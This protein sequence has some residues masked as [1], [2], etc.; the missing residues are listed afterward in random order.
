MDCIFVVLAL[1]LAG[2][3]QP[4]PDGPIGEVAGPGQAVA[5]PASQCPRTVACQY[6]E[7]NFLPSGYRV[8][9]LLVC[10]ANCTTQYWV[11]SSVD[12]RQL[13]EIDPVR[14]GGVLAVASAATDDGHASVRS[15]LPNYAPGDAGCCPSAFADV[16]YT[17][18]PSANS[19]LSGEP[20]LTPASD[21]PGWDAV[22]QALLQEGWIVVNV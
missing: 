6:A 16:T 14:G 5:M 15:V 11:S 20:V 13:V 19:M 12:G 18:D 8:Q 7:R 9:S 10:G 2:A 21:F 1:A 3:A 22:R 4:A 17:W